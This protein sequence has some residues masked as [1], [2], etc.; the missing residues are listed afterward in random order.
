VVK[1]AAAPLGA[2]A[3]FK[4]ANRYEK[5]QVENSYPKIW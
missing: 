4:K 2:A 3:F 1:Y 5:E